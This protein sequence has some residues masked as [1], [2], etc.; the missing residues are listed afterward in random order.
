MPFNVSALPPAVPFTVLSLVGWPK[1]VKFFLFLFLF[2]NCLLPFQDA[3]DRGWLLD[4]ASHFSGVL[5]LNRL[6]LTGLELA[7]ALAYLHRLDILHGDLTGGNV[8]LTSAPVTKDD[9]RGFTVKVKAV[10]EIEMQHT[11]TQLTQGT[12]SVKGTAATSRERGMIFV[13]DGH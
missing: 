7:K 12:S 1:L 8:M 13:P 9:P 4:E 2:S 5:G 10:S 11:A 6:L 3:V